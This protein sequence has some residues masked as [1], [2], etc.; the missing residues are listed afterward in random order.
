MNAKKYNLEAIKLCKEKHNLPFANLSRLFNEAKIRIRSSLR[1]F[2]TG[3]YFLF[4]VHHSGSRSTKMAA[5]DTMGKG[6]RG[7]ARS[8]HNGF[9]ISQLVI[10]ISLI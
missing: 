5:K 10:H 7:R 9:S 6:S 8:L 2:G 4:S 1:R 3:G